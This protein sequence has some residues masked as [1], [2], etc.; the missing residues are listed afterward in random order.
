MLTF[1]S[2][3]SRGFWDCFNFNESSFISFHPSRNRN[4]AHSGAYSTPLAYFPTK[5]TRMRPLRR[6]ESLLWLFLLVLGLSR[7]RRVEGTK[8]QRDNNN[9]NNDDDDDRASAA[10]IVW[11]DLSLT[12]TDG[13]TIILHPFSGRVAAGQVCGILGPSGAGKTSFLTALAG[14]TTLLDV[15]GQ[16]YTYHRT[17]TTQNWTIDHN[18]K[19]ETYQRLPSRQVAWLQQHDDFFSMLT[20]QETLELAAFLEL[21]HLA[22]AQRRELVQTQL[23]R[24]G[25]TKVTHRRV[26]EAASSTMQARISGGERRRLAVALELLTDKQ[27]LLADEATSGLD[28]SMSHRVV[29]L[30]RQ[31]AQ[32]G[33]IPAICSLHQP[34]SSIWKMLDYVIVMA[35]GG[36]VCYSGPRAECLPYFEQLGY[37]C[38]SETNPAEF[39]MDLISVETSTDQE[40]LDF[41]ISTFA[42]REETHNEIDP[43]AAVWRDVTTNGAAAS[44]SNFGLLT[45][46]RRFGALLRRSWRQNIRNC[47]IHA[48]R[49][50]ASAVNAALLAAIFPSVAPGKP[51]SP[52]SVADRVALLSFGAINMCFLAFMKVSPKVING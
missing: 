40:R 2:F 6:L 46:V 7:L 38:P 35:P 4:I 22:R 27:I 39:L 42:Q 3:S 50:V 24:L 21:P 26:G 30:I 47:N 36:H 25:L 34:R 23:H 28:A 37:P 19:D 13:K 1:T 33:H 11:Q 48:F 15:D 10:G 41:I 44:K 31:V 52:S 16:V 29:Q 17:T 12:T 5:K 51:P 9:N 18:D 43:N 8:P 45:V 14:L 49:L 20:V 32:D